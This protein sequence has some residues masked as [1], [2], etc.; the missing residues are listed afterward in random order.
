MT[1][2]KHVP[3][4]NLTEFCILDVAMGICISVNMVGSFIHQHGLRLEK[5][6]LKAQVSAAVLEAEGFL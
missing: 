2:T 1:C 6:V 4:S 3:F 5:P